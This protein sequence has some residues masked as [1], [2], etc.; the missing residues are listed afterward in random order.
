[1]FSYKML[2]NTSQLTD[3]TTPTS[4]RL[5]TTP[6]STVTMITVAMEWMHNYTD[7]QIHVNIQLTVLLF[8]FLYNYYNYFAE[9][10]I[11]SVIKQMTDS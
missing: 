11:I 7:H 10:K 3:E 4:P 8:L 6:T 2:C 5:K 9:E 1:M